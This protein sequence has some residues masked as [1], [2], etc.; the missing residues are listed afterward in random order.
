MSFPVPTITEV[1]RAYWE[2]LAAGKLRY[3]CCRACGH[4]WLP[5]RA[6]CPRCLAAGPEWRDASGRGTVLSW[7]V[8]HTAYAEHLKARVPYDVTLV[9]LEEGPRLLTNVINS[10]AGRR[11]SFGAPVTLAIE[12]EEGVAIPRFALNATEELR[13]D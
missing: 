1:N 7:V 12:T 10:G 6:N 11:L 4:S 5:P 2:G 9:E 3:Q 13:N 8:Y